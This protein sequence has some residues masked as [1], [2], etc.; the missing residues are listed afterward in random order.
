MGQLFSRL[1]F[2]SASGIQ[3][4]WDT[5]GL[6]LTLVERDPEIYLAGVILRRSISTIR[7]I[8]AYVAA[9]AARDQYK[10]TPKWRRILAS[11]TGQVSSTRVMIGSAEVIAGGVEA[12]A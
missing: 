1:F 9:L 5:S 7:P 12:K 10:E 4:Q 6:G 8:N 11:A 2:I 3:K